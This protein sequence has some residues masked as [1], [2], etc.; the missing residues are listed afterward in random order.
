[1][2]ERSLS[3]IPKITERISIFAMENPEI[4]QLQVYDNPNLDICSWSISIVV[5]SLIDVFCRN[6]L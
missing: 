4:A 6:D 2:K 1:M 3:G 5:D